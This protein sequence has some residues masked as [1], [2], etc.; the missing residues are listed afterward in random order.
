LVDNQPPSER[1]SLKLNPENLKL[2]L[3]HLPPRLLTGLF[4]IALGCGGGRAGSAG[5]EGEE[6]FGAAVEFHAAAGGFGDFLIFFAGEVLY[7]LQLLPE[8]CFD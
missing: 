3:P 2:S 5:V 8:L 4:G 7:L 6:V 1:S